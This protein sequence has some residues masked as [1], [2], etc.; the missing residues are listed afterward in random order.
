MTWALK[1]NQIHE[2]DDGLGVSVLEDGKPDEA[3]KHLE[4][5]YL[6]KHTAS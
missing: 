4:R 2:I 3:N 5:T 6:N 1:K